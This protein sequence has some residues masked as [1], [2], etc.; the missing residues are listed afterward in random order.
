MNFKTF[1]SIVGLVADA[2]HPVMIRGRHGVGKSE[3]VYSFAKAI[4]RPVVERRASQ[5]TEGDLVGLPIVEN[6]STAWNPPDWYKQACNE[7]VVLF[8]DEIDRA[9]QEVRQGFFQLTDS[10]TINGHK[11]HPDTL[12][13]AAC[14][15]G[16]HGAQYAVSDMDPAELDRWT[17]FD[18]EPT[19]EDWIDG[20]A[21]VNGRIN[22][23]IVDFIRDNNVQLEH[24]GEFEPNKK[25]PSRRSWVRF[26]DTVAHILSD[27]DWKKQTTTIYNVASGFLGFEAAVALK[28]YLDKYEKQLSVND[29]LTEGKHDKTKGFKLNDHIAL[30]DKILASGRIK[31]DMPK[32][33]MDNLARYFFLLPSEAAMKF[34]TNA[35]KGD[36]NI[37]F[38]LEFHKL[39]VDGKSVK[40]YIQDLLASNGKKKKA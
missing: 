16:V 3:T 23:M 15:G 27:K 26:N 8:M 22:N 30:S 19:V 40:S 28:D 6:D 31:K 7:P 39:N 33:E 14:N 29:I 11:L 1:G 21:S 35:T 2:R 20:F 32:A 4:G 34:Y 13:F 36:E 9:V 17:V 18:L 12:I 10:R 24:K 37:Q 25:Y 38:L 5:M